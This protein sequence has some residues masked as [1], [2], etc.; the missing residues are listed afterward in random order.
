MGGFSSMGVT[1]ECLFLPGHGGV[2]FF[3][4]KCNIYGNKWTGS[5]NIEEARFVRIVLRL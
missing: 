3:S 4:M 2:L 5:G 1:G